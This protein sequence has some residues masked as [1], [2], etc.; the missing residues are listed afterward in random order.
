MILNHCPMRTKMGLQLHREQ[1]QLCAQ[2]K[3]AM[4]TSLTDRMGANYP[5]MPLR[6]PEGCQIELMADKPL[7]LAGRL[8]DMPPLSWLLAFTDEPL[9]EQTRLTAHYAALLR[10]ETPPPL[11][12]KGSLGRFQD[13][14]L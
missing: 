10:G 12:V 11:P 7:H 4:G 14:V 1:C 9:S 6:M 13:G 5:L 2:G 3:G 8:D